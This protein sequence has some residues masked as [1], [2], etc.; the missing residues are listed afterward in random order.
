MA[1]MTA[2]AGLWQRLH[3]LPPGRAGVRRS[4]VLSFAIGWLPLALLSA[5]QGRLRGTPDEGPFLLDL[6]THVRILVAVP[7]LLV[8]ER[9]SAHLVARA[10]DQFADEGL[11]PREDRAFHAAAKT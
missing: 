11:V 4:F 5:V 2:D 6:A 8:T 3:L 10:I 7:L 9:V 1:S